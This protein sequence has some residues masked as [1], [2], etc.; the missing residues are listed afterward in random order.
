VPPPDREAAAALRVVLRADLEARFMPAD[1]VQFLVLLSSIDLWDAERTGFSEL[2]S[3]E[4]TQDTL[5]AMAFLPRLIDL[6]AAFTND[7]LPPVE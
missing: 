4:I 7:F 6:T 2:S 5:W 3:W 1:T